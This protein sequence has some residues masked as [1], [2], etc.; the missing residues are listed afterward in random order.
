MTLTVTERGDLSIA[1]V[2]ATILTFDGQAMTVSGEVT[3]S[4]TNA[5]PGAITTP[6]TVLFFEDIDYNSVYD[7][8]TDTMLGSIMV[9]DPLPAG[10]SLAVSTTLSGTVQF[11]GDLDLGLCGQRGCH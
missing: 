1:E 8:G 4:V 6:F 3:A 9:S 7:A 10:Q 5:G 2:D 11:S